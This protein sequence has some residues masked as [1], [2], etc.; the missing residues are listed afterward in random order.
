M[1]SRRRSKAETEST[2]S[3][4]ERLHRDVYRW[5]SR[6]VSEPPEFP[7]R[8]GS[9]GVHEICEASYGDM[10]A[11]TGFALAAAKP[12]REAIAWVMQR[13]LSLEHGAHLPGG[14]A[15]LRRE[16]PSLVSIEVSKLTD[17]LW[18]IEEAVRSAAVGCVIAE[19]EPMNFT[20]S[21]RLALASGRHGV[22]VILLLPYSCEGSTAASARW[23]VA[24]RPSSP[25]LFDA[26]APGHPRWRAVLERTR[27]APHLAG[28]VFDVE[29]NDETLSLSVVSGMATHAPATRT[30]RTAHRNDA[31][32]RKRA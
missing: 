5:R 25:N 27:L 4:G 14:A 30:P 13:R 23:R 15:Q 29:L 8:L 20:A 10:A 32:I 17:A 2:C 19:I 16:P 28:K 6:R 12:R 11:L 22:P 26:R 31:D 18:T 1:Q 3:P 21:R 7:F 24:P 9:E